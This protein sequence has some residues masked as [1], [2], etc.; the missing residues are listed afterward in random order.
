MCKKHHTR[1]RGAP[2]HA[3]LD[4]NKGHTH[5]LLER[6]LVTLFERVLVTFLER[7][8]VTLLERVLVTLLERV[9]VTLF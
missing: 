6:V 4:A 7:V 8:L 2:P 3:C 9:L 5:T 1:S